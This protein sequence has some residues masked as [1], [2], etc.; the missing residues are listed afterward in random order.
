M[1]KIIRYYTTAIFDCSGIAVKILR[2][3]RVLLFY[4]S[5]RHN[6]NIREKTVLGKKL[7]DLRIKKECTL[8]VVAKEV[9]VSVGSL[10]KYEKGIHM[11]RELILSRLAAFYGITVDELLDESDIR[12]IPENNSSEKVCPWRV[13]WS[14]DDTG[15]MLSEFM[16]CMGKKCMAYDGKGCVMFTVK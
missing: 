14:I 5:L 3:K 1:N 11:P 16:P 8:S 2:N 12:E 6:D 13:N 9:G 7:K 10:S 4:E 15:N